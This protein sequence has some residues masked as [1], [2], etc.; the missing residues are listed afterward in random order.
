MLVLLAYFFLKKFYN[1]RKFILFKDSDGGISLNR[2]GEGGFLK[3]LLSGQKKREES[4]AG[5]EIDFIGS[6]NPIGSSS[7]VSEQE[8]VKQSR[9]RLEETLKKEK[10]ILITPDKINKKVG[11]AKKGL[12]SKLKVGKQAVSE[13]KGRK[14][15]GLNLIDSK[16]ILSEL[17]TT[18][19][20]FILDSLKKED[21]D[22]LVRKLAQSN[23]YSKN[24]F[25]KY[26]IE[27]LSNML[28]EAY[29]E[30]YYRIS[31]L[32]KAGKKVSTLDFKLMSVPLK[33]KVFEATCSKKDFEK[34]INLMRDID[35]VLNEFSLETEDKNN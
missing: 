23:F 34:V 29:K 16:K 4:K 12:K 24:E 9:K 18:D 13:L 21:Y 3:A 8:R 35:L 1:K 22:F 28:R 25:I 19:L 31:K 5:K 2:G 17:K 32:R 26:L 10:K 15:T 30:L 6:N 20:G 7:R 27:E 14:I 11:V 33:I